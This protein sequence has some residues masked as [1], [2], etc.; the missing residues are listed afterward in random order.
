MIISRDIAPQGRLHLRSQV[1]QQ[2]ASTIQTLINTGFVPASVID[3]VSAD[4]D[5][6]RLQHT[7]L[8]S[9]QLQPPLTGPQPPAAYRVRTTFTASGVPSDARAGIPLGPFE[10]ETL[11]AGAVLP[12]DHPLVRAFPSLVEP[13]HVSSRQV[14]SRAEVLAKRDE[15]LRAGRTAG[16]RSIAAALH[17]SPDTVRRRLGGA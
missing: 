13:D 11:E 14:V 1:T 17:V 10:G 5:W 15:L 6:G 12:A 4:G 3:A 7:G 9:V 16:L 2:E 8:T